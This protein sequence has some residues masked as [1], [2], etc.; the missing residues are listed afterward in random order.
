MSEYRGR[1]AP[2]PTGLLHIGSLYTAVASYLEAKSQQGVWIVRMEDLDPPRCKPGASEHILHTLESFGLFWDEEVV[3]QSRRY[4]LYQDAFDALKSQQLIYPC[5]CSR[6]Q[7]HDEALGMGVDGFIYS[8]RCLALSDT[9]QDS[10]QKSPAWRFKV[11]NQSIEFDDAIM[12]LYQQNLA[13]D[14]GDFI[15]LRADGFWAYQ[16]AVIV[17][18]EEQKIN[19]IVRGKDLLVSTPRQIALQNALDFN[20]QQYAHLPLLTNHLGQKWSKQTLA[21]ALDEKDKER[22][23][24]QVFQYL[25]L[26]EPPDNSMTVE[27]LLSWAVAKWSM[28][29]LPKEDIDTE[30]MFFKS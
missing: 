22:L 6:R 19:H 12:G 1:F 4:H 30:K 28:G 7:V 25:Y 5:Y 26:P 27:N 3:Y 18:D 13:S 23:L 20:M 15:L 2:S 17:D 14:I 21:P 24:R 10:L 8:G 11:K 16:L 9:K 29:R